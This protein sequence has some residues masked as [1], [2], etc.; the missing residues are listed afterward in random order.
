LSQ[1]LLWLRLCFIFFALI[2]NSEYVGQS[3]SKVCVY[4]NVNPLG[5]TEPLR[6]QGAITTSPHKVLNIDL[7]LEKYNQE[8]LEWWYTFLPFLCPGTGAEKADSSGAA[9]GPTVQTKPDR[10]HVAASVWKLCY[11]RI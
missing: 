7:L 6:P 11:S 1:S 8:N 4:E 10:T 2:P 9:V 3:L 5:Q